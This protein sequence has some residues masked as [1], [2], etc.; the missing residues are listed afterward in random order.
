M[1]HAFG[2]RFTYSFPKGSI[3]PNGYV[4]VFLN[5]ELIEAVVPPLHGKFYDYVLD[6]KGRGLPDTKDGESEKLE[7]VLYT[8]YNDTS[9]IVDRSSV[10]IRVG[11]QA[12]IPIPNEGIKLR[13][14]FVPGRQMI[15]DLTQHV[16]VS[17]MSEDQNVNG[18]K[19]A[20]F[21]TEAETV[22]LSYDVVN[23]Y[24]DGDGLLRMQALPDKG[25]DFADLTPVNSE[26]Q[27]RFYDTDMIPIYM[28]VNSLGHEVF[29]SLPAYVGFETD[30]GSVNTGGLIAD[31]PLPT[32]PSKAVHIG[33]SWASRFQRENLDLTKGYELDTLVAK[34]PARGEFANVEWERGHPCARLKN[35][36]EAGTE[37]EESKKLAAQGA[38]FTGDKV[39]IEETIWFALDTHEI[40]KIERDLTID[41]KIENQAA[42]GQFAGPGS[43][44]GT[45]A[46]P[47]MGAP[48]GGRPGGMRPGGMG[49][50]Q[51]EQITP[52]L[53]DFQRPGFAPPGGF[54]GGRG[55][56]PS[57]GQG[58]P[59]MG[60]TGMPG[61]F[62][63]GR[64]SGV[65]AP[66]ATFIRLHI[67]QTF[68]LEK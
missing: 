23:S 10:N 35:T 51:Q 19:A 32:L 49:G 52:P 9:R 3:P 31:Y 15:Y 64:Q 11:N 37:S 18:G 44:G 17:P 21:D 30:S 29:G 54:R 12:S 27:E 47:F 55:G 50:G 68:T 61:G 60:P 62:G 39:G 34:F 2:K 25:K 63:A 7:L 6:T 65:A 38:E 16:Q 4:G 5:N 36:I 46:A 1:A 67:L 41:R 48:G 58:V 14:K 20:T 45:G 13:Y 43:P 40:L 57:M 8:D 24:G 59:G 22:R 33:D 53:T 26:T 56:R 28:R 66:Q 42:A